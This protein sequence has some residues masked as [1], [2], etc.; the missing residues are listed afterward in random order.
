ME[1]EDPLKSLQSSTFLGMKQ[2]FI[3]VLF[4]G[5][6]VEIST[7]R[8]PILSLHISPQRQDM[9]VKFVDPF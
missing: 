9:N 3:F 2:S 5:K 7:M 6:R 4:V 1:L 8:R